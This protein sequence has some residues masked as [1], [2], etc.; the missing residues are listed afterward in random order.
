MLREYHQ[1]STEAMVI[2]SDLILDRIAP[3]RR[4]DVRQEA[5]GRFEQLER[6]ARELKEMLEASV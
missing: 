4:E 5:I 3:S 2:G 1:R 6:M